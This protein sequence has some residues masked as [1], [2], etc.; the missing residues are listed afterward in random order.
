MSRAKRPR[1]YFR[2]A[3]PARYPAHSP[4]WCSLRCAAEWA[5]QLLDTEDAD[6][7][8]SCCGS[9]ETD[10][11]HSCPPLSDSA[12]ALLE[13]RRKLGDRKARE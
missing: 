12:E 13:L 7:W 8:R 3:K 1:C 9:W 10:V 2:C 4:R 5:A 6:S 11:S